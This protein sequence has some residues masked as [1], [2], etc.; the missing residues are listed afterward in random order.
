[1]RDRDINQPELT[2]LSG[3]DQ[4]L[5]SRYLRGDPKARLPKLDNLIA[6]AAA[7]E[8]SLD[9]FVE[10]PQPKSRLIKQ[11]EI[12]PTEKQLALWRK[13]AELPTG[14]WLKAVID[15]ALLGEIPEP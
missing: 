5:I 1:M 12:A 9:D 3:V 4:S 10:S 14:H 7:L 11:V 6:L 2:R 8:C 15:Q 13:Y